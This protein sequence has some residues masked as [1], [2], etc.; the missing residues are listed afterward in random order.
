MS[1]PAASSSVSTTVNYL[2]L[3][4]HYLTTLLIYLYHKCN[5][6]S[7]IS[8]VLKRRGVLINTE[9]EYRVGPY[10]VL[11]V[12]IKSIEWPKLMKYSKR[13][14]HRFFNEWE[15]NQARRF[16]TLSE[17]D[18]QEITRS[19]CMSPFLYV[20]NKWMYALSMHGNEFIAHFLGLLHHFPRIISIPLCWC[21]FHWI[22]PSIIT[23]Y[24]LEGVADGTFALCMLC[25][26][27]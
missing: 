6:D 12:N 21:L 20:Q 17:G 11:A 7:L 4:Q 2:Y 8:P 25:F 9:I 3:H 24:I 22:M 23:L 27:H 14:V 19:V 16:H 18:E 10:F 13:L 5:T 15:D 26:S 1:H